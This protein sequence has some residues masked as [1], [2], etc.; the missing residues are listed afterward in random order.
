MVYMEIQEWRFQDI[1]RNHGFS[2]DGAKLLFQIV[3]DLG[4]DYELDP[5]ELRCT[6][7]EYS[8]DAAA[9]LAGI[10]YSEE[11]QD[12]VDEDGEPLRDAA[13]TI[14]EE[15]ERQGYSV[16]GYKSIFIVVN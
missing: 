14:K 1:M 8:I 13:K 2:Y 15:L 7:S 9:E 10:Q 11:E 3:S 16:W 12:F 6:Y 5:V 4:E